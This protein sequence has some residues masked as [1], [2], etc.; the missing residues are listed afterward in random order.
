V[1]LVL[2]VGVVV[3]N[4]PQLDA[5]LNGL[6][7]EARLDAQLE[8]AIARAGGPGAVLACAKPITGAYQVPILAWY[9]HVHSI[10]VGLNP[11]P[12]A[13][14]FRANFA[15]MPPVPTQ[16]PYREVATAGGWHV[17]EACR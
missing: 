17:Y 6:R 13:V 16:P 5:V 11:R 8:T 4:R 1:G 7:G 14:V 2:V 15:R 3:Y 10:R 9:L 12:P